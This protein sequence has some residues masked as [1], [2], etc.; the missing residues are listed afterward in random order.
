VL[1]AQAASLVRGSVYPV[2]DPTLPFLGVH[3]T[4][5]VD[6]SVW[7]GPNA[8]VSLSQPR[9]LA[10][11][12]RFGGTWRLFARHW[13]TGARE[14]WHDQVR[15]ASVREV[16]RYLPSLTVD[17]IEPGLRPRGVRAQA[18]RRDGALVDDFVLDVRGRVVHVLNAPSPA[19]T[20]A[21]A[22]ADR[23]AREVLGND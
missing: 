16:A 8:V 10:H 7:A 18:V 20:S 9:L 13:R 1:R 6:G 23:I 14:L 22:I 12:L 17:D 2:P 19:A 5:R 21:F 11:A 15:R 4:R 3:L